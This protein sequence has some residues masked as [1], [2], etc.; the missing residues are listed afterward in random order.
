MADEKGVDAV[1]RA[2]SILACFDANRQSLSLAEIAK[3][4]ALYK[5]TILRLI[6]SLRKFDY[7]HR[8]ADNRYR[9]GASA[10]R[11]GSLFQQGFACADV[12]RP[13]LQH[14]SHSTCETASFYARVGDQ[15][16]CLYRSEPA[17]AIR[18]SITEGTSL[19]LEKGASG[20]VL[21][22]FSS[23]DERY[24]A[25]RERGYAV[26]LG[27]RDSEVAAVAVPLWQASG[28]LAGAIAVSGLIDR[29]D[30]QRQQQF[31]DELLACQRR[32][33]AP[34]EADQPS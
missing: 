34:H 13:E 17:R 7:L 4:T 1:E 15:R 20:Q 26:S 10:W 32:L 28:E 24:Q 29:F 6:V 9:L 22:A 8:S 30:A 18:H 31:V 11:L 27:E 3:D 21:L 16:V 12:I 14:L 2:L 5:S 33:R 19:P 23:P 25:V